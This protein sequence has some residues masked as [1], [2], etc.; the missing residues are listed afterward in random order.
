MV[1][2]EVCNVKISPSWYRQWRCPSKGFKQ[3]TI[4]SKTY[5]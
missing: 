1:Y 5:T 3:L 2:Q 4:I